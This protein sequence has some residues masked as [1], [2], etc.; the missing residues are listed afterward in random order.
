[1]TSYMK[2]E[3]SKKRTIIKKDASNIIKGFIERTKNLGL[4]HKGTEGQLKE[5]FLGKV[6]KLFLSQQFD[7]GSGIVINDAGEESSQTDIII[8]DKR[9]IPPFIHEGNIGVYPVE[10]VVAAIEVKTTLKNNK[11]DGFK[12]LVEDAHKLDDIYKR[13]TFYKDKEGKYLK[14]KKPIYPRPPFFAVLGIKESMPKL[15][16]KNEQEAKD[17]L[18]ENSKNI[19]AIC[20]VNKYSWIRMGPPEV[21]WKFQTGGKKVDN[22]YT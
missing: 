1:M 12:K 4:N 3:T 14:A 10:S 6:L 17:W 11:K 22:E 13:C 8:Y 19:S 5:L 7:I 9:L 20:I 21:G 18:G 15:L 2:N 16:R